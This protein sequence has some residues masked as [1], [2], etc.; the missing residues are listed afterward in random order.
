MLVADGFYCKPKRKLTTYDHD[1]PGYYGYVGSQEECAKKCLS[2]VSETTEM[3][4]YANRYKDNRDIG[5]RCKTRNLNQCQCYCLTPSH[6]Q[7]N[8]IE[9]HLCVYERMEE[10]EGASLYS[11]KGN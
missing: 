5:P 8:I 3:F 7:G 9:N 1:S 10:D 6:A 2:E 11:I 4:V